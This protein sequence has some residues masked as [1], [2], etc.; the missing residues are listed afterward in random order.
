MQYPVLRAGKVSIE[1]LPQVYLQATVKCERAHDRVTKSRGAC[2]ARS[3]SLHAKG[4]N[5]RAH[6]RVTKSRGACEARSASLH[7][8]D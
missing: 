3:A 6:D 7:A 4:E 8:K 1:T 2:E 5:E